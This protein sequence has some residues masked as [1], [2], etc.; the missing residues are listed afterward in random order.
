MPLIHLFENNTFEMGNWLH[1]LK[2]IFKFI[3]IIALV[4]WVLKDD[5][6]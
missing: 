4:P 2:N 3:Q 6:I 5:Q 1:G